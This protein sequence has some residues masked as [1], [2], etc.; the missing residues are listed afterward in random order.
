MENLVVCFNAVA[1]LFLMLLLGYG[2]RR[3]G[4]LPEE[5]VPIITSMAYKILIFFMVFYGISTVD[6]STAM[7]PGVMLYIGAGSVLLTLLFIPIMCKLEPDRRSCGVLVE[8]VFHINYIIMAIP[9]LE[10]LMGPQGRAVASVMSIVVIPMENILA[11]LVLSW[12]NG[13][14]IHFKKV[15]TDLLKNPLIL[16]ALAAFAVLLLDLQLPDFFLSTCSQLATAC[17]PVCLLCLGATLQFKDLRAS[18]RL[19]AI[20]AINRL[21][22]APAIAIPVAI[23]LGFR[24]VDLAVITVAFSTSVAATAF[25]V[26]DQLGGDG[27]LMANVI[28]VT[29]ALACFGIFVYTFLLKQAGLI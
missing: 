15:C 25:P 8:S 29:S 23:L 11:V 19:I 21:V 24:G 9:I 20:A 16:G 1:P 26:C 28:V 6:L 22:A 14:S 4:I 13:S 5:N 12:F 10:T 3:V 27:K 17:T 2:A 18:S 7:R